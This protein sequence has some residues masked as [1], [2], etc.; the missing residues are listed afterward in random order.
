[1][2]AVRRGRTKVVSG[3]TNYIA[4]SA[5]NFVPNALITRVVGKALRTRYQAKNK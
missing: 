2:N 1:M 3:W 5:A 4:A